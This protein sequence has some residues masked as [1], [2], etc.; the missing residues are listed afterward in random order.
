[1][2]Q[3]RLKKVML[4]AVFFCLFIAIGLVAYYVPLVM[5]EEPARAQPVEEALPVEAMVVAREDVPVT[6]SGFGEANALD[7]VD[8]TPEV[9]GRVV[10]VHPRLE[11][12]EVIAEGDT[13]F[14]IDPR[15]YRAQL[16]RARAQVLQWENS[17]ARLQKQREID[18]QRL[19]TLRRSFRLGEE[20]FGRV[21]TLFEEDEVGTRSGVDQAEISMN[22]AMEQRDTL[23]QQVALYPAR[24]AEAEASLAAA[25]ADRDL[26]EVSLERTELVAPFDARVKRVSVEKGQYVSPG[27]AVLTLANDSMLEIAVPIDSIEARRWLQ[28]TER[29]PSGTNNAWFN[30]TKPVTCTIRWTEEPEQHAWQGTLARIEAFDPDSRTLTV[31]VRVEGEQAISQRGEGLPLVD[32]MFCEVDIPGKTMEQVMAVPR[33]AVSFEDTLY[34]ANEEDRLELREVEVAHTQGEQSF[35]RSGIEPGDTVVVTRLVN[36]LLNTKLEVRRF[37][38]DLEGARL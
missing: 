17:I 38:G 35:V 24:I 23:A 22:Q 36:P 27:N 32:G 13:L 16:E 21:R 25:K 7:E 11:V 29:R 9:P 5:A 31:A 34:V 19:E 3:G 18:T 20:E 1:M 33:W 37:E 28:F 10:A 6:I 4:T 15:D 12:G 2:S 8:I 30:E 14:R 26:A